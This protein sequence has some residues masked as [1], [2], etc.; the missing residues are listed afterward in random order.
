[1]IDHDVTAPFALWQHLHFVVSH[2][3][4]QIASRTVGHFLVLPFE[5]GIER[6]VVGFIVFHIPHSATPFSP[7]HIVFG[8]N[9]PHLA[10]QNVRA[11]IGHFAFERT[12]RRKPK[13]VGVSIDDPIGMVLRLGQPHHTV[14]P[15]F[16]F[17]V[18][19]G[20]LDDVQYP[21]AFLI[22]L[23]D[24]RCIIGGVIVGDDKSV[25]PHPVV[26]LQIVRQHLR[27]V[28]HQQRHNEARMAGA[29][30]RLRQ[31]SEGPANL[32]AKSRRFH[33]HIYRI[34]NG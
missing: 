23:Q 13:F 20:F 30:Q 18:G 24:L 7:R 4:L 14:H 5:Y 15:T 3:N 2:R 8:I 27:F 10:G 22:L 31:F 17:I 11:R 16:L 1:M 19:G 26:E 12:G 29:A 21:A 25:H 28:F 9:A 32:E 6:E 33:T 34:I